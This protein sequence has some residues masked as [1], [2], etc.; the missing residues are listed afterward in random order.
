[1][2]THP[3]PILLALLVLILVHSIHAQVST[4]LENPWEKENNADSQK[5]TTTPIQLASP[6]FLP[7][8][9]TPSQIQHIKQHRGPSKMLVSTAFILSFG[10][11]VAGIAYLITGFWGLLLIAIVVGLFELVTLIKRDVHSLSSQILPSSSS[12]SFEDGLDQDMEKSFAQSM[13]QDPSWSRSLHKHYQNYLGPQAIHTLVKKSVDS[14]GLD[15]FCALDEE[16]H[17]ERRGVDVV[18]GKLHENANAFMHVVMTR[19]NQDQNGI[20]RKDDLQGNEDEG[21]HDLVLEEC[22]G[23]ECSRPRHHPTS[24]SSSSSSSLDD[25]GDHEH[26]VWAGLKRVFK[27]WV[28]K[29]NAWIHQHLSKRGLEYENGVA[30]SSRVLMRRGR[31]GSCHGN[32]CRVQ[33][34]SHHGRPVPPPSHPTP[35]P[36]TSKPDDGD[37]EHTV[38]AGIKRV[39][40]SWVRKTKAW[41]RG[42]LHLQRRST[43]LPSEQDESTEELTPVETKTDISTP[44]LPLR[45]RIKA[46]LQRF[47]LRVLHWKEKVFGKKQQDVIRRK[48]EKRVNKMRPR[49]IAA[50]DITCRRYGY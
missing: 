37:H 46:W 20:Q 47:R 13:S 33:H 19:V 18:L 25:K 15:S 34:H 42:D 30:A 10:L 41:F 38:W 16:K 9:S 39:V 14:L 31:Y 11:V 28:R 24:S 4:G 29:S 1:M 22:G 8:Q 36:A 40:R 43:P 50:A 2:T 45:E 27:S 21:D 7:S 17:G 23:D 32:A 3:Y 49:I 12:S 48:V 35:P 44:K 5:H 26:T 6:P